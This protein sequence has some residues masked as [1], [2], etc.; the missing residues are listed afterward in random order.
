MANSPPLSLNPSKKPFPTY[1][2]TTQV[3]DWI[4]EDSIGFYDIKESSQAPS[5]K[6]CLV[7]FSPLFSP[8]ENPF[9]LQA[10]RSI[11]AEAGTILAWASFKNEA[12]SVLWSLQQS[13]IMTV[14]E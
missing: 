12:L 11:D 10:I 14:L 2:W 3:D 1:I 8:I 4:E 13:S 5:Q 6:P 9:S 7:F